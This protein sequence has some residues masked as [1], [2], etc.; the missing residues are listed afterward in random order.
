M[1]KIE[2]KKLNLVIN[3]LVNEF[4]PEKI[5]LFGSHA[6]GTP[7]R[8]SDF[9]LLVVIE[10]SDLPPSRRAAKAY[11]CLQGTKVPVEIL[12]NTLHELEKYRS[13]PASLTK[14]ILEEGITIYG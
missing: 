13:V 7:H 11:R 10:K 4:A 1:E 3:R 5:I 6:W 12:V 2:K 9:D 8:D 14:K